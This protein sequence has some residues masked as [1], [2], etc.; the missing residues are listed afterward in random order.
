VHQVK[1]PVGLIGLQARIPDSH[2]DGIRTELIWPDKEVD[3]QQKEDITQIQ[4]NIEDT[5]HGRG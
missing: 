5:P 1:L 4:L 2:K 3:G